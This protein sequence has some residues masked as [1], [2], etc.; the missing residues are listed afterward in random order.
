MWVRYILSGV[1]LRFSQPSFM[2]CM[3][4]C[5]LSLP[6][7]LMMSVRMCVLYLIISTKW[8]EWLIYYCLGLGHETRDCAV[9]LS[10]SVNVP[11]GFISMN[12]CNTSWTLNFVPPMLPWWLYIIESKMIRSKRNEILII[13]PPCDY[14]KAKNTALQNSDKKHSRAILHHAY[15]EEC[16]TVC[17][18]PLRKVK[19]PCIQIV[20]T[21]LLFVP[22]CTRVST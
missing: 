19:D 7:Y 13:C 16:D 8:E 1:C 14:K 18:W 12:L 4:L 5:A 22:L 21:I 6:I 9:C 10:I 11:C 15:F 3:G 20:N 17:A 2:Q